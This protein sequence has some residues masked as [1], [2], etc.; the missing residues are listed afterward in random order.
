M[1]SP[2]ELYRRITS[3]PLDKQLYVAADMVA[4]GRLPLMRT[5][6][7]LL[8]LI[9]VNLS[10]AI[11]AA[12]RAAKEKEVKSVRERLGRDKSVPGHPGDPE[13]L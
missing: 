13:L 11:K 9:E 5:V 4:T 6:E 8:R 3:L 1:T 10:L 7:P 12:E 2:E